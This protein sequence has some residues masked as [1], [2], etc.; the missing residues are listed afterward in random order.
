MANVKVNI[1]VNSGQVEIASTKTLT[2]TEQVRILKKELQKLPEGT[3][4]WTLVQQKFN[5][6]KDSLDRVNVKS[7]ELFGTLGALPGQFGN[8]ASQAD[9]SIG[10]LKTF[11]KIS[12]KDLKS[13]FVELG[14]DFVGIGKNLLV[15]T[16]IQ[17]VYTTTVNTLTVAEGGATIATKLFAG[18]VATLYAAL[19]AGIITLLVMGA[20]ALYEWGSN[21]YSG[22]DKM[23]ALTKSIENQQTTLEE[24]NTAIED[25]A[26]LNATKAK[27]AGQTETEI[28]AIEQQSYAARIT[29]LSNANLNLLA[30]YIK[31]KNDRIYQTEE[32]KKIIEGLE[33]TINKNSADQTKLE[34][35]QKQQQADFDLAQLQKA[36][37]NRLAVIDNAGKR[38][39]ALIALARAKALAN[40]KLTE[41]ERNDIENKAIID[42]L[43]TQKKNLNKRLVVLKNAGQSQ[44]NEANAVATQIIEVES[45]IQVAKNNKD[46][47]AL[48]LAKK[49]NDKLIERI[50]EYGATRQKYYKEDLDS[51][52][53]TLDQSL[54]K[55]QIT[56]E[57]YRFEKARIEAA[58]AVKISEDA[59]RVQNEQL[60]ALERNNALGIYTTE[61]YQ[62]RKLKIVEEYEGKQNEAISKIRNKELTD[63]EL[64]RDVQKQY[65]EDTF[66]YLQASKQAWVD[67]GN[68]VASALGS[69]AS[70][71]EEGSDAQ[72]I[73]AILSV[74]VS[75][76]A[77]VGNVI[78]QTNSAIAS[79]TKSGADGLAAQASGTAMFPLNPILGAALLASGT[80]AVAA[81]GAGIAAAKISQGL[82]IGAI[83]LGAAAQIAAIT[84]KGKSNTGSSSG[85]STS[86]AGSSSTPAF[87]MPSI[88]APQI[89]ASNAQTGVIAGTVA[90]AIGANNSTMQP[91]KAYVVGNDITTEMQL[92]RRLRTM[93]RLGG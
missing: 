65:A 93:A 87:N 43:E 90:G 39:L 33:K 53:S 86:G 6:T 56:E 35:Q 58:Y 48:E 13:Q 83:G 46:Q 2:L 74:L 7:K 30:Q 24:Y 67:Y 1:D 55:K 82:S 66:L 59:K 51:E 3:K 88:G 85:G 21:A 45:A 92:Q 79:L 42:G 22:K 89:G 77:A 73:F 52:L 49:T 25:N 84:S 27:I 14:K 32:G 78:I 28:Q 61:E 17:K 76:A 34:N 18:A 47:Q 19:G 41:K 63:I 12:V 15:L 29:N 31:I 50:K 23:D 60:A 16:G 80:A 91:I 8:I 57:E 68:S 64:L 20:Q 81:S 69:V 10:V 40:L 11:S 26:K 54:A 71:L 70:M 62:D 44:V 37:Q 72:K 4:E 36:L 38:E 5:E 9:Q 75:S